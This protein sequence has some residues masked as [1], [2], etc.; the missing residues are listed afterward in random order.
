MNGGAAT[1]A[2]FAIAVAPNGA[3]RAKSDHGRLPTTAGEIARDAAEALEAG[4]AMIHV[5]VRDRE[6]RHSL[7]AELYRDAIAQVRE[8]VGERMVVQIT[9][10][11]V[12]RYTPCEQMAV[13][14]ELQPESVSVALREILPEFADEGPVARFFERTAAAGTLVQLIIYDASELVQ[15]RRLAARGVLPDPTP[16][17]LA[18][19]GRYS[20]SGATDAELDAYLEAG[21][22][23]F[24]WMLCAF[25]PNEA[26]FAMRAAMQGGDARVG[27]ENNL[28][29]P[30]GS[31]AP[32]NAAIV[33]AAAAAASRS[34]RPLASAGDLR[35]SW[36]RTPCGPATLTPGS[37]SPRRVG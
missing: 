5:H 21:I 8:A 2:P 13:V 14:D 22:S 37:I 35:R 31:L 4:A 24:P 6:G 29:L 10:E 12:G 33:A 32:N 27:F 11:A 30:D 7:D 15:I 20:Q 28:W 19:L 9:T 26:H 23:R 36:K 25:G 16:P 3:R 1:T 34:G 17:V 18:V